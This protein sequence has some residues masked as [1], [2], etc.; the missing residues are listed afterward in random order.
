MIGITSYG[1]FIPR[2]RLNRMAIFQTM[3][4]FAPAVMMVAQGERSMCNWDEDSITMAVGAARDCLTGFDKTGVN[5]LYLASTS[6]PFKD[7]QNA[8]I[9]S[10]ALNLSEHIATADYTACLRSGTSALISAIESVKSKEKD[11]I[12]VT[13]T[14]AR[15]TKPAYF[16]EMWYGDGAASISVGSKDVIAEFKGSYSVAKDFVDHYKGSDRRFDYFW[17]ERWVRDEGFGKIIPEAVSGL[18]AKTGISGEQVDHFVFPCFFKKDRKK[19]AKLSGINPEVITD[20]MHEVCGDTGAAHPLLMLAGALEK[21]KPNDII[22]VAGFGQGCDA[23]CFQVTKNISKLP[24]RSGVSGALENKLTID[25]YAKFLVFRQIIEP[26]MGIRAEAPLQTAMTTLYRKR[27]MLLGLMGGKCKECGT[28][29]FPK[30]EVCVNPDCGAMH[31]QEDYEFADKPAKVKSFTGDM[32]SVS[33]DPPNIYGMVEFENG[34]RFMADFTD[35]TLEEV[36]VGLP[37]QMVFRRRVKDPERGFSSYFWKAKPVPGA[38]EEMNKIRFDGRVAIITGA[39]GGLGKAYALELARRG[40]KI[41]VNDLGGSRDGSGKG[42]KSPAETVVKEIKDMG[43]KA[44]ANFDNVATPE[45]G[46]KIVQSAIDAFGRVDIV[47][48][49]AGILRDKSFVKMEPENWD[50][51]VA[52]HLKGAY[53]VTRPAFKHMKENGYGRIIMTTSAAGLYGNFGQANYSAAK[54]GLVGFM[55]TLKI[56]GAKYDIKVNTIAPLAASRLTEDIMPPDIFEKMKPE[57]IVPMVAWLCSDACDKSGNIY[58]AGMG[59]YSR[60]AILTGKPVQ[61]GTKDELPGPEDIHKNWDAINDLEGGRELADLNAATMDLL[62]GGGDDGGKGA[63]GDTGGDQGGQLTPQAIFDMMPDAFKPD[64]A[65]G[66]DV[67]FQY[68]LSGPNG[69]HWVVTVKDQTCKVE[70]GKADK[71]TCTIKMTD[72]NFIK[73]VTGKLNPMKAF[74]SGDLVIEGDVMKSQLIEKLFTLQ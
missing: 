1:A 69:G 43:G 66:V 47:V 9:V 54:L 70:T 65:A 57:Y 72:D 21:A 15:E 3:G 64:A 29:Q 49:N 39:G 11:N 23:L 8:S 2:Y 71:A 12:L 48:N 35:C 36:K 38:Q 5:A 73:L 6:L 25:N 67:V 61:I 74:S 37:V 4:W 58:N 68:S 56:E 7:R 55:N 14:D 62:T 42:S 10:T 17:E 28:P 32:L 50:A 27:H 31:S 13:A 45:G 16:Y 52:V 24:D 19:I 53:N 41:V 22:V 26:D 51:V 18:L 30:T 60:A 44:V 20:A 63:G 46:E 33:V 40:A 34:G 59:Y